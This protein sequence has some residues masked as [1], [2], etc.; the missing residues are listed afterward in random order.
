MA[1]INQITLNDL[2]FPTVLQQISEYCITESGA[3]RAQRLTPF[4]NHPKIHKE[5][6][7]VQEF[8]GS[9]GSDNPIPSHGFENIDKELQYLSIENSRIEVRSEEHT[10]ELQ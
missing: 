6:S 8:T 5:L 9:F 1:Q 4:R 2:E 3:D 10:S 7:R